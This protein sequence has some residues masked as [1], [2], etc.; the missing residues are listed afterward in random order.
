MHCGHE[1]WIAAQLEEI[2]EIEEDG[3]AV[4]HFVRGAYGEGKTHFLHYIQELARERKWATAHVECR[5]DNAEI[6]HF[7]T[8]YPTIIQKL[9]LFPDVLENEEEATEDPAWKL[10][11]LW[12][13]KLLKESGYS[14]Q[15]VMRPY[16]VETKLFDILQVKV[17]R[18]NLPGDFQRVICAYPRSVLTEDY[19][20][21]TDLI[22]WLKGENQRI[23]IPSVY[24]SKPGQRVNSPGVDPRLVGAISIRPITAG[25]SLDVFRGLI[26]VLTECGFKGLILSIDEVEHIAKLTP[27]IRRDR[28]L[29]TLREFVD[30][31]DG[32]V[33]LQ[34][35][36]IYFAATP[37]MFDD[38]KYFRSYDALATRIEPVSTE[39]NWRAPVIDL[40]KTA[41]SKDQLRIVAERIR[42]IFGHAYGQI[43]SRKLTDDQLEKIVTAADQ[44]RYRIAKPRLLCRSVVDQLQRLTQGKVALDADLLISQTATQVLQES[45]Q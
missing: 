15:P 44:S 14:K 20:T 8:M 17:M 7:E 3:G 27:T 30:N 29:Q 19:N 40:E 1:N 33:G 42:M 23:H 18:R 9:R 45:E 2:E 28:S 35:I 38:E 12:T 4:V 25:T 34:K 10:L 6:D 21:Q 5:K 41:L 16:E 37:Q 43:A 13:E 36:S 11:Q 39:I 22:N 26:W 32:D 31:T 24:L